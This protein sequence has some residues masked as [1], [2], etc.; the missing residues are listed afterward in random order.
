[1]N[2]VDAVVETAALAAFAPLVGRTFVPI[3]SVLSFASPAAAAVAIALTS[4]SAA[5]A[6]GFMPYDFNNDGNADLVVGVPFEDIGAKTDAGAVNVIYGSITGLRALNNQFWHLNSPGIQGKAARRDGFGTAIASGD[7]NADGHADLAIGI[8]FR[9]VDGEADAGAVLTL[10]GSPTGLTNVGDQLW[11]QNSTD[12]DGDC[13]QNDL[14]GSA[15]ASGDFDGDGYSD[16]AIGVPG[17]TVGTRIGA[18]GVNILYGSAAG[19]TADDDQLWT[20]NSGGVPDSSE[21]GDAF[22]SSL[23]AGDFNNDGRDDL[24]VGSPLERI[25]AV[26]G[27]GMIHI[28]YGRAS[29][30][31]A[32]GCTAFNQGGGGILDAAELNDNFGASLAAGDFD[33]DFHDDLAIGAPREDV[34]A[35][36][37]AGAVHALY[38]SAAGL[39]AAGN[40]LWTQNS[41]GIADSCEDDDAFGT[42]LAAA[43]FDGDGRCDLAIGAP[44]EDV[45]FGPSAGT[46]HIIFGRNSGLHRDRNLQYT[47]TDQPLAFVGAALAAHDYNTDGYADLTVGMPGQVASG[48]AGAGAAFSLYSSDQGP[49]TNTYYYATQD[50]TDILDQVELND[51]FGASL[52][53]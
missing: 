49:S 28:I 10:Y 1:M 48:I 42:S 35:R 3:R 52:G 4:T 9:N 41:K 27:A 24:A 37:D 5:T 36:T 29:G 22:G 32:A 25:G 38:G 19:L 14:F 43:D 30:L 34:G 47:L 51:R 46:V 26:V 33:N 13:T 16:L 23:A 7:F 44:G 15:L 11:T 31:G 18:G 20:Q 6:G 45:G 12:V 50:Q 21:T 2:A 40:Q 8:P 53:R 17:E 39:A